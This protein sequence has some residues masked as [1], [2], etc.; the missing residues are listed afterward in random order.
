MT[1]SVYR[2]ETGR[3]AVEAW[4]E[5]ALDGW[6]HT[7]QRTIVGRTHITSAGDGPPV[8][9]LPGTN[10][11]A[12][13]MLPFLDYLATRCRCHA[14]DLPGQPGLSDATRIRPL[15]AHRRWLD[16]VLGWLDARP[17]VVGHSLGA[18]IAM[19][20][21]PS[22]VAGLVLVNPA[23]FIPARMTP[24]L[25]GATLPWLVHPTEATATGLVRFMTAGGTP[26]TA[27]PTWLA[28]VGRAC[29]PSTAP[30][31]LPADTLTSLQAV[32]VRVVA[33]A[34]DPFFPVARLLAAVARSGIGGGAAPVVVAGGG[35]LL[36]D[37]NPAEVTALIEAVHNL[38]A[39][40]G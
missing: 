2:S 11:C 29:H 24:R 1:R 37:Q 34:A 13:A 9:V 17:I 7:H 27:V 39:P 14:V 15:A 28:I 5:A 26:P 33:G 35:H 12:A 19:Q 40:E 6:D 36:L 38:D 31:P 21:D 30:A 20:I 32:P 4:C 3:R 22:R 8:V 23:G 18:A 25:L 16:D 10:F